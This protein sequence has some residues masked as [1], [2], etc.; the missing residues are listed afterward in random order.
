MVLMFYFNKI[1]IKKHGLGLIQKL[2]I[3]RQEQVKMFIST[4]S[5]EMVKADLL[6]E[7]VLEASVQSVFWLRCCAHCTGQRLLFTSYISE[8]KIR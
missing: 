3:V 5:I 2:R 7:S 4:N 6:Q 1:K 8:P